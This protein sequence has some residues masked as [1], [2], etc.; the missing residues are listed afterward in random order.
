VK[1][2]FLLAA[3]IKRKKIRTFLTL[4][5]YFTAFLLFGLLSAI[6]SAFNQGVDV[7]GANRIV[8]GNKTSIIMPLPISYMEKF[9]ELNG[10]KNVT[11][12]SWFGGYYK[13]PKNFFAQMAV[14]SYTYFDVYSEFKIEKNQ[15]LDFMKDRQGCI[16]GKKTA[17]K[18]GFKIGDKIPII[19]SVWGG[20]WEFNLRAIYTGT[21]PEDDL[22][23][24][25]FHASYLEE[26]RPWGKGMVGW[27]IVE[28]EKPELAFSISREIDSIFSNS[29]YETKSDT[30]KAFA[31]GFVKQ[32]GNIELIILSIGAIVFLT[33]LLV[34][35]NTM[36]LSVRERSAEFAVLKTIGFSDSLLYFLTISESLFYSFMGGSLGIL[37]AK[38]F[39]LKGDPTGGFLPVFYISMNQ[40]VL[41][42]LLIFVFGFLSGILPARRVYKLRIVEALGRI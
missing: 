13:D 33:L 6:K 15:F 40:M 42:F 18:Y 17:E 12:A 27:Y 19:A 14:D 35:S 32:I 16:V 36:E 23:Q 8:V 1:F 21:K 38:L 37:V 4:G 5:S 2:L 41:G 3:N 28:I 11:Y 20:V 10:V 29:P 31:L 9:F 22:T 34:T 26:R 30:E 39:T 25:F 7:A 24:F